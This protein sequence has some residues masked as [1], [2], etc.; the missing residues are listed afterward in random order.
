MRNVL[1]RRLIAV[2]EVLDRNLV[3][4]PEI[5]EYVLPYAGLQPGRWQRT[6]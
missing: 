4:V 5:D 3:T 2:V 1:R 6:R